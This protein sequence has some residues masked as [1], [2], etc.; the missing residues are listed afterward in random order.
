MWDVPRVFRMIVVVVVRAVLVVEV[1]V[2]E[3]G[4]RRVLGCTGARRAVA[5]HVRQV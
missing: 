4:R 5:V 1:V 3:D 2:P